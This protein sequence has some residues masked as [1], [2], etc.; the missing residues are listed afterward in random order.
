MFSALLVRGSG[1]LDL[2]CSKT[3]RKFLVSTRRRGFYASLTRRP[4]AEIVV[5]ATA[6][7]TFSLGHR[8]S[9]GHFART[10]H[11]TECSADRFEE[12]LTLCSPWRC[13]PRLSHARHCVYVYAAAIVSN[14]DDGSTS[15]RV[16]LE[17][18]TRVW[19]LPFLKTQ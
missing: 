8:V 3:P 9:G 6:L 12:A 17:D 18:K 1:D 4:P 13:L 11:T 2:E 14:C 16:A 7:F 19:I 15:I 10:G 5:R